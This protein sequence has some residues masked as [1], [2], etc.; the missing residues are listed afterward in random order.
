MPRDE[1]FRIHVNASADHQLLQA[2][3]SQTQKSISPGLKRRRWRFDR[4][5]TSICWRRVMISAG[6]AARPRMQSRRVSS[7]E[8]RTKIMAEKPNC[9]RG[10]VQLL[11]KRTKFLVGTGGRR[12]EWGSGA[13]V[14]GRVA[15]R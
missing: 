15:Q 2:R 10:Q 3:E 14:H 8:R 12:G 5:R 4:C 11:E 9:Q 1:G 6:S 13:V 7:N